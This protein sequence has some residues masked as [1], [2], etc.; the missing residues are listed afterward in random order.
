MHV[1]AFLSVRDCARARVFE[2][3]DLVVT[4]T[5]TPGG[6]KAAQPM[7]EGDRVLVHQLVRLVD[8]AC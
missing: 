3:S 4:A 8:A 1:E 7:A 2:S 5:F 6:E